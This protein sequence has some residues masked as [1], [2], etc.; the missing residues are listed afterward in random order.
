MTEKLERNQEFKDFICEIE[1]KN[2]QEYF[3]SYYELKEHIIC[4]HPRSNYGF[5]LRLEDIE[6]ALVDHKLMELYHE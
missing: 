2:C 4:K 5:H 6:R 3:D 1:P